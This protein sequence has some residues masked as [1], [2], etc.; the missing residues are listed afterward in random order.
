MSPET[1]ESVK[2]EVKA[3]E[4]PAVEEHKFP[5]LPNGPS[6]FYETDL[7]EFWVG[8]PFDKIMDPNLVTAAIDRAKYDALVY[9]GAYHQDRARKN[10]LSL[11]P[12]GNR[13]KKTMNDLFEKGK[14]LIMP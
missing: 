11:S 13:I 14:S 8:I 9:L 4:Q 10:A 3:A 6:A 2:E 7:H 5:A 12:T 1:I